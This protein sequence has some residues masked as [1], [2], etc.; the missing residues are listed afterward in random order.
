MRARLDRAR[1]LRVGAGLAVVLAASAC[2]S[3]EGITD[4]KG[5]DGGGGASSGS[6]GSSGGGGDAAGS[7]SGS[8]GSIGADGSDAPTCAEST[9]QCDPGGGGVETCTSGT[10]STPVPCAQGTCAGGA[11][12]GSCTTGASQCSGTSLQKCT[13]A[14]QW[15]TPTACSGAHQSCTGGGD[16][17]PAGCTC[18]ADPC[19]TAAMGGAAACEGPS[20][21]ATCA[22]DG[23]GCWFGSSPAACANGACF[24]S[25]GSA[26]CCTNMCTV[27][28]RACVSDTSKVETCAV[29]AGGNTRLLDLEHGALRQRQELLG[30]GRLHLRRAYVVRHG[31]RRHDN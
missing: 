1:G 14:D 23:Q 30:P 15:G 6:S 20:I 18:N 31:V 21:L 24:G 19:S 17:G 7:S 4:I 29:P 11:C 27:G 12:T 13:A 2:A 9:T 10:W 3:L 22:Q 26:Q 8:S 16:A 25:V 5:V 28:A